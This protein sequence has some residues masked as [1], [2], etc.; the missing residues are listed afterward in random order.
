MFGLL[1]EADLM[2]AIE[3]EMIRNLDYN[4][5]LPMGFGFSIMRMKRGANKV[6]HDLSKKIA[7]PPGKY[8]AGNDALERFIH[9]SFFPDGYLYYC[10]GPKIMKDVLTLS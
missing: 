2:V 3:V 5:W 9:Q 7:K 4:K 6:R 8:S 1:L 10:F